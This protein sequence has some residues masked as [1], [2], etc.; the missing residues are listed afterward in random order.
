MDPGSTFRIS[1]RS[2]AKVRLRREG[3]LNLPP[4]ALQR[5]SRDD[6]RTRGVVDRQLG[7][8]L[9]PFDRHPRC[10]SSEL[11]TVRPGSS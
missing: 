9:E 6:Q 4:P 2:G 1:R 3:L 5:R 11:L 10:R 8:R 7:D